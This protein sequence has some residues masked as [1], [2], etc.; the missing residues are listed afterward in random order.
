MSQQIKSLV[1]R[2]LYTLALLVSIQLVMTTVFPALGMEQFRL[3]FN[4]LIVLY[5]AFYLNTTYFA[6]MVLMIQYTYSFFTVE[7]WAI[8]TIAG[9]TISVIISYLKDLIN[10]SSYFM[11][12]IFTW[13]FQLVWF[14]ISSFFLY[15]R[16][17]NYSYI[18]ERFFQFLTESL[19]LAILAPFFFLILDKIWKISRKNQYGEE[20]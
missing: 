19:V 20:N 11:V 4:I 14:L 5:F 1:L 13:L 18:G 16:L 10:L 8:G 2:I 9:I 12:I 15:L 7:N 17:D 6:L 3:G